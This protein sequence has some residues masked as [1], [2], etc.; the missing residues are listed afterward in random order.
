MKKAY[1]L[2][3]ALSLGCS[4]SRPEFTEGACEARLGHPMMDENYRSDFV[5]LF[6]VG[7]H[8]SLTQ[9]TNPKPLDLSGIE[10]MNP[11]F[12]DDAEPGFL[13]TIG[14]EAHPLF[15]GDW[16][17][18]SQMA[19][20]TAVLYV[21]PDAELCLTSHRDRDG[22]HQTTYDV[23]HSPGHTQWG[24]GYSTESFVVQLDE[25]SGDIWVAQRGEPT[26]IK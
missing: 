20:D 18:M 5:S 7:P 19:F 24:P 13:G 21:G 2:A 3:V 23:I 12:H 14:S 16:S 25:A 6:D 8:P 17:E 15:A 11:L 1:L 26:S 4:Q 22:V 9:G 10:Y